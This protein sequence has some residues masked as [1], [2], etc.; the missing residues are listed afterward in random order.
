[1]FIRQKP[2]KSGKIS[3]Q[4]ISKRNSKYK[5]V[6]T[7]GCSA[8]KTVIENLLIEANF[9]INQY[10]GTQELDFANGDDDHFYKLVS[11]S[12]LEHYLVGPNLVLGKLFDE[13]GFNKVSDI[14]FKHLVISRVIYPTS[15]LKTADY[16]LKYTGEQIDVSKIYRYLDKLTDVE[17]KRIQKISYEHT[18]TI[19]EQQI[20]IMLYDVTT[21]YFE[22]RNE[23]ELRKNGFSKD[24]KHAQ[25][26]IVLGLLVT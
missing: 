11:Q 21:I 4:V 14:I 16:I 13:I 19:V 7:I 5:V 18:L 26:Q 24:G 15:K 25:P 6:K 9:F 22:S 8:D 12:I 20:S 17:I 3:V 23:D 1:M 2:N 10:K